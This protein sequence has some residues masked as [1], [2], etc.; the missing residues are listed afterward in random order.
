MTRLLMGSS[1]YVVQRHEKERSSRG[2]RRS[3]AVRPMATNALISRHTPSV[4]AE[5]VEAFAQLIEPL[6]ASVDSGITPKEA[7]VQVWTALL[8]IGRLVLVAV[9]AALCRRRAEQAVEALG[10]RTFDVEWRVD[11]SYWI[12]QTTTL[13]RVRFPVF[14]FREPSQKRT[15]APG[16]ETFPLHDRCRSSELLLEWESLL[17]SE[18]P[19]RHAETALTYFTH[20]AVELEDTTI[21]RHAVRVGASI[22]RSW[23][24]R[25]KE[26]IVEIL[27]DRATRDTET[28]R[29]I[30]YFSTDA[31]ALRRFVDD[32]WEAP[33]KMANG[34]RIWCIDRE[35]DEIVHLGGEFT[36]GDCHEV[37]RIVCEL[38]RSGILPVAGKYENGLLVRVGL[39]TDGQQW[40]EEHILP[41]FPDAV[42]ILDIYHVFEKLAAAVA[43]KHGKGTKATRR[44]YRR[45]MDKLGIRPRRRRRTRSRRGH[46]KRPA[47]AGRR[48][49]KLTDREI[50][51]SGRQLLDFVREQT[52]APNA[53][54]SQAFADLTRYIE[55]NLYRM[56]YGALRKR[57][58]QIGSG[59]M[60]SLHRTG[61]QLRLKL[62]GSRW[63]KE[64]SQAIFNLRMLARVDRWAEFW[65]QPDLT[66]Q[67]VRAF[68]RS[69]DSPSTS[70]T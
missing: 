65:N 54:G 12:T 41:L 7:E 31:H 44:V 52:P 8:K 53:S 57:G 63:T 60:E 11:E 29:P 2:G 49:R 13:G 3:L 30:V 39:V 45:G 69:I 67:L 34:I 32:S 16:R 19:F 37:A 48:S 66:T 15:M 10:L 36:W 20:G 59:A 43:A 21:E 50:A 17:G 42:V 47:G 1:V 24:Y 40:I 5:L 56:E 4:T 14:A 38:Q 18:H 9:F 27:R 70:G 6:F 46:S 22:P 33:W 61:S 23:L 25:P 28:N 68:A 55:H 64:S 58:F 35:T 26:E 51:G 62:P